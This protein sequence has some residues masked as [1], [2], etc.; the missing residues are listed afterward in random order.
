MNSIYVME[1]R[2]KIPDFPLKNYPNSNRIYSVFVMYEYIEYIHLTTTAKNKKKYV[3]QMAVS[4]V[5]LRNNRLWTAMINV[6]IQ[7]QNIFSNDFS[8]NEVKVKTKVKRRKK[9]ILSSRYQV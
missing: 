8:W 9:K 5:L 7:F 2:T 1:I 4:S 3:Q 6:I